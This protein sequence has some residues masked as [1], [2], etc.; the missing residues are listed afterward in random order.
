[1]LIFVAITV[2]LACAVYLLRRSV[3]GKVA[4]MLLTLS[5]C[6]TALETYYRHFY[7]RSDGFG[8]LSRN[9]A[10]RYYQIDAH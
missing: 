5:V 1:M 7:V 6:F 3:A 10:D 9:F 8:R 4:L 2:A